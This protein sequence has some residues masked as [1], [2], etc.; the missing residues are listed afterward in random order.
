M[1]YLTGVHLPN[2][3]GTP[4]TVGALEEHLFAKYG[5]FL[6]VKQEFLILTRLSVLLSV[7]TRVY[8]KSELLGLF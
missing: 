6:S 4:A 3:T 5:Y 1:E 8:E 2:F 7:L